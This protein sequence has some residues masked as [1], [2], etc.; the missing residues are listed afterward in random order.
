MTVSYNLDVSQSSSLAFVRLLFRWKGSVWRSVYKE[1]L[2]WLIMYYIVFFIYRYALNDQQQEVFS[3]IAE[4]SDKELSY[5]PLTFLL[6][7]FVSIV[8]DRWRQIFNNIGFIENNALTISYIIRGSDEETVKIRRSLIRY[9]VLAQ[10]LV[11]RNISMKVRRRFP[12]MESIIRQGF[13]TVE[14]RDLLISIET[15]YNKYWVP[16]QWAMNAVLDKVDK[17]KIAATYHN[18]VANEFKLFRTNLSML[19]NFDWVPIPLAYPQVVFLAV[20]F[21][22]LVCVVSRQFILPKQ[23][24]DKTGVDLF[25]PVMTIV[26]FILLM[27]WMKIAEALLNPL[28][29]DDDDFECNFLIDKNLITGLTIVDKASD[30]KPPIIK[31]KFMDPRF[32]RPR[33][34]NLVKGSAAAVVLRDSEG[35]EGSCEEADSNKDLLKTKRERLRERLGTIFSISSQEHEFTRTGSYNRGYFAQMSQISRY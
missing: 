11:F 21:H 29:E 3:R 23:G 13:M 27:G 22:F 17:D 18:I 19:A 1:L 6:G 24:E 33:R 8:I 5:I 9:L 4:G 15:P 25:V 2:I 26:Q 28:G 12:T 32:F 7:F 16:I 20:R 35:N 10:V 34:G 30:I 31:D 14:E